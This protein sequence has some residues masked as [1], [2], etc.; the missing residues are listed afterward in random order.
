[1]AVG[2]GLRTV[3]ATIELDTPTI[4]RVMPKEIERRNSFSVMNATQGSEVDLRQTEHPAACP[5]R[6]VF[7]VNPRMPFG[8]FFTSPHPVRLR[9]GMRLLRLCGFHAETI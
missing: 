6:T 8:S 2:T 1:M 4:A 3:L 9:S 7:P 5:P